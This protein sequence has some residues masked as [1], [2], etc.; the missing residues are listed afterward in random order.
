VNRENTLGEIDTDVD[1]SH[2]L[3]PFEREL[4]NIAIPTWHSLPKTA[5]AISVRDREVHFIRWAY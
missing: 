3:P 2:E 1:N 4:M 5:S